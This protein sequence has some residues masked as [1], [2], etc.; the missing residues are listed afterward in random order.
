MKSKIIIVLAL[1]A[2]IIVAILFS[3]NYGR[4]QLCE[5]Y[6]SRTAFPVYVEKIIPGSEIHKFNFLICQ[7]DRGILTEKPPVLSCSTGVMVDIVVAF[8][9]PMDW[10]QSIIK[11]VGRP[12]TDNALEN[13]QQNYKKQ[14]R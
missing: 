2:T 3:G 9:E 5:S 12:E 8:G 4:C 11:I 14:L 1:C 10:T 7:K 6:G 13:K